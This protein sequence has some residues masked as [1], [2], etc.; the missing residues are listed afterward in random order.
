MQR[1]VIS[2]IVPAIGFAAQAVTFAGLP[3]AVRARLSSEGVVESQFGAWLERL[4][5]ETAQ[6]EREGELD[7]S[8]YYA[9]QSRS[10]TKLPPLEPALSAKE[11]AETGAVPTSA[12]LRLQAFRAALRGSGGGERMA[13][14][15][16]IAAGADLE[17]EYRRAM[18]FLYEKE[19]GGNKSYARRGHSTDT[20]F[21]VNYTVWTALQ[22][23]K[24][25]ARRVLVIGPGLDFAPRTALAETTRPQSFQPYAVLDALPEARI[26]CYDINDRVIRYINNFGRHPVIEIPPTEGNA[27]VQAYLKAFTL[28]PDASRRVTAQKHNILTDPTER[29]YDLVIATNVLV[30][31]DGAELTLALANIAAHLAPG[32][33][34]IHNDLRPELDLAAQAAGLEA[35]AARTLQITRDGFRFVCDL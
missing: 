30:Y 20:A 9:L 11:F 7:H 29:A 13:E 33:Y 26:D 8:I 12:A 24:P 2:M 17:G 10:F 18:K 16:R 28:R 32:G 14:F 23:L 21:T 4:R 15:R 31:Y 35:L 27:D 1:L 19:F 3:A 34:F 6:R 5:M 25:A 22:V